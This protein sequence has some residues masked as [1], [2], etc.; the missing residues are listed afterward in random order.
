VRVEGVSKVFGSTTVL[1]DVSLEIA[2]TEFVTLLGPSGSGKTTLLRIIA[3]LITPDAG[4]VRFGERSV[5]RLPPNKRNIAMVFQDYALYPN[6][7]V[8]DNIAFCLKLQGLSANETAQRVDAVARTL[9]ID[10]FLGR[11]P[12]ELSGGQKQRVAL[13]RAMVRRPDVFLL[14]EPLSNLDAQLRSAM[15]AELQKIHGSMGV[16]MVHVTHDQEEAL[17][18]SERVALIN[19][20]RVE[21]YGTPDDLYRR[22]ANLAV[23][24]FIGTPPINTLACR[25]A[26]ADDGWRVSG[27]GYAFG[28]PRARLHPQPNAAL[29]NVLLGIRPE[30]LQIVS[31]AASPEALRG[32]VTVVEHLG[33]ETLAHLASPHG[34]ELVLRAPKDAPIRVGET[35]ALTAR[36]EDLYFFD[37]QSGAALR[38]VAR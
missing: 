6:M 36:A 33:R 3:G 22:P 12:H 30:D 9:G 20:G 21:Q 25:I 16:T 37:G 4:D 27:D 1:D 17:S 19:H 32:T 14:D 10:P 28:L 2:D 15:R 23:A 18:V 5:L 26:P 11:W 29:D 24:R 31:T 34:T 7:R 35:L 13:G 38:G 8:R